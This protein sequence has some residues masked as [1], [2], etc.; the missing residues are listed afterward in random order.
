[1]KPLPPVASSREGGKAEMALLGGTWSS[2]SH[3]E[4]SPVISHS[5]PSAFIQYFHFYGIPIPVPALS[6]SLC[7][8]MGDVSLTSGRAP[9]TAT[10]QRVLANP[11]PST[12]YP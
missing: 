1:M 5:K 6:R 9:A 7:R 12:V 11:S 3:G 10:K 4:A 8:L 2:R